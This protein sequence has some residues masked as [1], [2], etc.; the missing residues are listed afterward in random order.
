MGAKERKK[1]QA[2]KFAGVV[3]TL[4]LSRGRHHKDHHQAKQNM[5]HI[6]DHVIKRATH[7]VVKNATPRVIDTATPQVVEKANRDQPQKVYVPVRELQ[8]TPPPT[9][10]VQTH[11]VHVVSHPPPQYVHPPQV[12]HQLP[13]VTVS[14]QVTHP[15][16]Q[17]LPAPVQLATGHPPRVIVSE[18]PR[19]IQ[20]EYFTT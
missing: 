15:P 13:Q 6:T 4:L 18:T 10:Y 7:H 17:L 16:Q 1:K 14:P 12:V 8:P 20:Q 3:N 19:Q 11:P 9:A 2:N 5:D